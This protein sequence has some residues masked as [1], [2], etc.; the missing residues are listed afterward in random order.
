MAKITKVG[1]VVLGCRD[2]QASVTFYTETLGLELVQF[3]QEL[4]VAFFSCGEQHHDI[5]VIKVPDD[6]P[7]G[8]AGLSHTA[9]QIEGGEAELRELY[10]RLKDHGVTV[11]FTADHVIS[12]SVYCFDPDGN[13]L[14]IFCESM[15]MAAAK[16]YLRTTHD[17]SKLMAPWH[18][19]PTTA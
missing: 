18:L 15:E 14:E 1:H 4:Q 8:S 13:R 5:A 3:N 9:L 2:P 16:H 10:Q 19:E 12:K 17:L 7:V 6:H 11:D